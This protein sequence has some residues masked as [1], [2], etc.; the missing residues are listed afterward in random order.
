LGSPS[1]KREI[2]DKIARCVG[3]RLD[4]DFDYVDYIEPTE[5]GKHV[6]VKQ[7]LPSPPAFAGDVDS[8]D[9]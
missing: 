7:P 6:F 1:D 4:I 9:G 8:P 2:R 5:R 3:R